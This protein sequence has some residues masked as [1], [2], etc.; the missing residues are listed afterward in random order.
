MSDTNGLLQV[1]LVLEFEV[2]SAGACVCW[3]VVMC[4]VVDY[5][6]IIDNTRDCTAI[7][8]FKSNC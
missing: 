2:P 3:G 1:C 5:D 7:G 6:E 8:I 4:R